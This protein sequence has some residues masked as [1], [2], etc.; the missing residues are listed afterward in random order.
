MKFDICLMNP[1]YSQRN[2]N[3]PIHFKFTEKILNISKAQV[4]VMPSRIIQTTSKNYDPWKKLFSK[5]LLSVEEYLGN[6][7]SDTTMYNVG[8]FVFNSNKSSNSIKIK[9]LNSD[10][11]VEVNS[12]LDSKKHDTYEE[13]ILKLLNNGGNIT[14]FNLKTMVPKS[15]SKQ[16]IIDDKT[17]IVNKIRNNY[18]HKY[19]LSVNI[20]NGSMN[21]TYISSKCGIVF[22]NFDDILTD[23]IN[24]N[25]GAIKYIV[26]N[27]YK[28]AQNCKDAMMRPL[29][30]FALYRT[31]DDQNLNN[32][33]YKYIPAINWEDDRVKTDEG[34]L[35]VCG[36]P[37]DKAKEYAEYCKKIIEEVDKK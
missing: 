15:A 22:D 21:G 6:T 2:N 14:L 16:K 36:C 12:L 18:K 1:P 19:I 4:V 31:Q 9:L 28:E 5:T 35:Q 7:F 29:L 26:F 30:R 33:C 23:W 37:A 27:S 32:K 13:N 3:D 25:V 10:N 8:I 34:L 11:Y 17:N 20:A 24:R